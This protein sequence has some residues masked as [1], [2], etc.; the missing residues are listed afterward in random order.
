[1]TATTESLNTIIRKDAE[2]QLEFCVD[3]LLALRRDWSKNKCK[4][5]RDSLQP[6]AN[7]TQ[8]QSDIRKLRRELLYLNEL[9]SKRGAE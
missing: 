3:L 6:I 4:E 9:L 2:M 1:M 8:L 5:K 7:S